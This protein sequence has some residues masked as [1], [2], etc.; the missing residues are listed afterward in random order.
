MNDIITQTRMRRWLAQRERIE[1]VIGK[2][3]CTFAYVRDN[4]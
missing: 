4:S 1:D 3:M 2:I